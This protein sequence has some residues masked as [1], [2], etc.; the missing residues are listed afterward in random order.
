MKGD[1]R[2]EAFIIL[3]FVAIVGFGLIKNRRA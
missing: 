1:S 2:M 3:G